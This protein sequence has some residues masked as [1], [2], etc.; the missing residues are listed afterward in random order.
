MPEQLQRLLRSMAVIDESKEYYALTLTLSDTGNIEWGMQSHWAGW[1][2]DKHR[3]EL[4]EATRV[5][6]E[7]MSRLWTDLGQTFVVVETA[8]A[9]SIYLRCGGNALVET[10]IANRW[11][12]DLAAPLECARSGAWGFRVVKG[13]EAAECRKAP[14][15]KQRM[16]ILKRDQYKC[17][18]CG[19][20]PADHTDVE[21]H[22]HHIRPSGL[23]G[24]TEDINLI[25]LCETCHDGLEPHGD[26]GLFEF[27]DKRIS[28]PAPQQVAEYHA[29]VKRYRL[30]VA[31]L[32]ERAKESPRSRSKRNDTPIRRVASKR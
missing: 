31:Q 8:A 24:L 29:R 13:V 4:R 19:R 27:T 32:L 23:G 21:L 12:P 6:P 9:L 28:S 25:T 2:D 5:D 16:R 1:A 20:R 18:L 7:R 3:R 30:H 17:V 15:R 26:L 22:V 11:L 10:G 14:T